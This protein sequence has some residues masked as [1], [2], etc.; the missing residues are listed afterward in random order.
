MFESI[1][2]RGGQSYLDTNI[3]VGTFAEAL[4]FYQNVHLVLDRS[5]LVLLVKDVGIDN[6]R[7]LLDSGACTATFFRDMTGV[8]GQP[9][10]GT[11]LTELQFVSFEF[12]GAD[13]KARKLRD[14]EQFLDPFMRDK[15]PNFP[16]GKLERLFERISVKH[17]DDLR[18]QGVGPI[19]AAQ[20]DLDDGQYIWRAVTDLLKEFVPEF[21]ASPSDY[22]RIKRLSES[23]FIIETNLNFDQLNTLYHA[24]VPPGHSTI[25]PDYLMAHMLTTRWNLALA[26]KYGTD[27]VTSDISSH[28]LELRL[29]GIL[30]KRSA[31][32]ARLSRFENVILQ[33]TKSVREAIDSGSLTFD[34]FMK[35]L[36]EADKFKRWLKGKPMDVDLVDSYYQ[37][38]SKKGWI[39][40][41]PAR[42]TRFTLFT[43][44]GFGASALTSGAGGVAAGVGLAAFDSFVID[45]IVRGWKPNQFVEGSMKRILKG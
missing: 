3:D 1:T 31:N 41:L 16:T 43:L 39:D 24:R 38:I 19:Q 22:F 23:K 36:E 37:E 27:L 40:K 12:S 35:L 44:L 7:L 42:A 15:N 30:E 20:G 9:L 13:A 8:V 5:N 33:K 18:V 6:F 2:L 14:K 29:R 34:N 17:T 45:K 25:T 21:Q 32:A 26:L 28:L 4:L 10:S 11:A